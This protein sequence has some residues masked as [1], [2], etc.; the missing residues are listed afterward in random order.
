MCRAV[1][2]PRCDTHDGE[3]AAVD[4]DRPS[5]DAAVPAIPLLPDVEPQDDGGLVI[6]PDEAPDR[7]GQP[8]E[9]EVAGRDQVP[10]HGNG[11]LVGGQR[12]GPELVAREG[13]EVRGHGVFV[14]LE[15]RIRNRVDPQRNGSTALPRLVDP[16]DALRVDLK[17]RHDEGVREA[18]HRHGHR[19]P[20]ADGDQGYRENRGPPDQGACRVVRV[21]NDV[22]DP[23]E[24]TGLMEFS[25]AMVS[26]GGSRV[27]EEC[28]PT[29]EDRLSQEVGHGAPDKSSAPGESDSIL[30]ARVEPG[31]LEHREHVLTVSMAHPSGEDP[32]E[33]AVHPAGPCAGRV[34]VSGASAGRPRSPGSPSTR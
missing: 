7:R 21:P 14:R 17:R 26:Q 20:Q 19:R 15:T 18:E 32:E 29:H 12:E 13:C 34:H 27:T 10:R 22:G 28:I 6:T 5:H 3:R 23:I 31:I 24:A 2:V 8:E 30:A 4:L 11:A 9:G 1:E 25:R 33:R 16:V